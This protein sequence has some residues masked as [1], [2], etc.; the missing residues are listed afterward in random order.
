MGKRERLPHSNLIFLISDLSIVWQG[1]KKKPS[2]KIN[3]L[4]PGHH[5]SPVTWTPSFPS[6]IN[7]ERKNLISSSLG[8]LTCDCL[9]APVTQ[10]QS[11][12][13]YTQYGEAIQRNWHWKPLVLLILQVLQGKLMLAPTSPISSKESTRQRPYPLEKNFSPNLPCAHDIPGAKSI[14]P[15]ACQGH[16]HTLPGKFLSNWGGQA[17]ARSPIGRGTG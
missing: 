14:F 6:G 2:M 16:S 5:G 12:T 8:L 13:S 17:P 1:L 4:F 10:L 7:P 3:L 9:M 11:Y 15:T